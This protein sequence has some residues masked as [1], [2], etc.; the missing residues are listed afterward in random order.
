M[1]DPP[2]GFIYQRI[3]FLVWCQKCK[4]TVMQ[5]TRISA[6]NRVSRFRRTD[7]AARELFERMR[8]TIRFR[9]A[10]PFSLVNNRGGFYL[11]YNEFGQKKKCFSNFS[12]LRFVNESLPLPRDTRV[13]H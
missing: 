1:C 2:E 4:R 5:V 10:E 7:E 6:K 3:D 8:S 9:I 13:F 12:S 11:C